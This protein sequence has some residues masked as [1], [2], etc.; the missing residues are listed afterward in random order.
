MPLSCYHAVKRTDGS[1][2][3]FPTASYI[4]AVFV[5][6]RSGSMSTMGDAPKEG[7]AD[8]LVKHRELA[9]KNPDSEIVVTVVTFDNQSQVAYSGPAKN[10]TE[11]HIQKA[12]R[13]MVP[14]NTTRLIDT[15][16]EE[17]E[18]QAKVLAKARLRWHDPC[19]RSQISAEVR[20]LKPTIAS[21]FTLLTDGSDNE[22][23][24]WSCDLNDAVQKH[25]RENNTVCLFAA[26]NQDAMMSGPHYGFSRECSLQIGDDADEARAAFDS[27]N[28]AAVR[29]VTKQSSGYTQCEREASFSGYHDGD[30][31]SDAV[32]TT[33]GGGEIDRWGALTYP[34]ATRN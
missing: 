16:I 8:F 2:R 26:A 4:N 18:N 1:A 12:K 6:D 19:A 30:E 10:I 11:E 29:S 33:L 13:F 5:G 7:V 21:S 24:H 34:A 15:A 14:R 22:S 28:A 20:R 25:K 17:I 32:L 23:R 3:P 9:E 31:D 27:C